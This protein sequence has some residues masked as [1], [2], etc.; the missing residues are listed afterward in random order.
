MLERRGHTEAT[1]E[2]CKLAG[3]RPAG[4]LCELVT[5][6]EEVRDRSE[7]KAAGMMTRDGCLRF[8]RDW[9]IKVCTIEDLVVYLEARASANG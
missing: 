7:R 1:M 8:G 3:K 5:D 9:G 4:A 6:G 2:F